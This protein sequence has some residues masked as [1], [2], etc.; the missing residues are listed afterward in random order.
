MVKENLKSMTEAIGASETT[1]SLEA[2]SALRESIFL[3]LVKDQGDY[4][5]IEE[6]TKDH[7]FLGKRMNDILQTMR[8]AMEISEDQLLLTTLTS[9]RQEFFLDLVK[10]EAQLLPEALEAVQYSKKKGKIVAIT[11]SGTSKYINLTLDIFKLRPYVDFIVGEE[12]VQRGK[13]FPDIYEKAY[14][15]LPK[16]TQITKE[17]CLV[18]WRW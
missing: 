3:Q 6:K 4:A 18:I 5:K 1:V 16:V 13:P 9:K 15:M 12:Y 2:L 17:E 10:H 11:S 7:D 8:D 14:L